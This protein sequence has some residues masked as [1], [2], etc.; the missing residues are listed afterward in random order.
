MGGELGVLVADPQPLRIEAQ[1]EL[2]ESYL[3]E[4]PEYEGTEAWP[5]LMQ[6]AEEI[7]DLIDARGGLRPFPRRRHVR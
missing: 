6:R 2:T 1:N 5:M 4:I 7:E 3:E